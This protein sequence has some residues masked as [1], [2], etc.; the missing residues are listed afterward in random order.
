MNDVIPLVMRGSATKEQKEL[1]YSL[2]QGNVRRIL[3][4]DEEYP[5]LFELTEL[6]DFE[7]PQTKASAY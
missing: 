2:W 5:G 4:E 3:L 1:F 6:K 7:F